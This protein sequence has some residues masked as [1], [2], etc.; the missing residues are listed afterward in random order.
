MY[1]FSTTFRVLYADTDNMQFM[2]YGNY[3]K[4]YEMVRT[5]ALRSLGLPYLELEQSGVAMP[6]I[7]MSVK[8]LK[9]AYYDQLLTITVK[10]EELPSTRMFFSYEIFNE[11]GTLINQGETTL[12]F[13]NISS[14]KPVRAPEILVD[15]LRPYF[16]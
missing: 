11:D 8:Y 10:V 5:E 15:R 12:I 14:K 2:Y 1:T 9:P 6:V 13:I 7:S 3:A 16:S 4:Y